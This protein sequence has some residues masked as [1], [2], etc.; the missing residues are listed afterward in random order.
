MSDIRDRSEIAR[1]INV[2]VDARLHDRQSG[3]RHVA[4]YALG[5]CLFG[6]ALWVLTTLAVE[7]GLINLRL[8]DQYWIAVFPLLAG[9]ASVWTAFRHDRELREV[10]QQFLSSRIDSLADRREHLS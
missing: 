8:S 5:W 3:A 7:A 2:L 6:L 9:I 10:E 4:L 1:Y